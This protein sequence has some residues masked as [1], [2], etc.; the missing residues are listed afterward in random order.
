MGDK[1]AM[2]L[3]ECAKWIIRKNV[4]IITVW[5]TDCIPKR[6]LVKRV[7]KMTNSVEKH[8]QTLTRIAINVWE[9]RM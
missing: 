6:Q 4:F 3:Y 1:N 7:N 5:E 2:S 8:S 9:L